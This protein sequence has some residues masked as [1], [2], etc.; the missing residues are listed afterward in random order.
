MPVILFTEDNCA[1]DKLYPFTLTRRIADIRLG[2]LTLRQK[3]ELLLGM[4]SANQWQGDYLDTPASLRLND[5]LPPGLYLLLPANILPNSMIAAQIKKLKS[6]QCLTDETGEVIALLFAAATIKKGKVPVQQTIGITETINR[7]QYGWQLPG[8]NDAALREDFA[9]LTK[10]KRKAVISKTNRCINAGNIFIAPGATVEHC[11]LNAADG[12]VYIDKDATV[13]EGSMLRGPVAIGQG[14]VVKM[15]T[16][17]YGATTIGPHCIAGGEIKNSILFG[18]SNK[19]HDGYLGDS[20]IGEWCN[21]G[22]G[23]SNSNLKNNAGE[24][25]YTTGPT[26]SIK[27][28]LLMGDHS[29]AAINSSFNTAATVGV[30]CNVFGAGLSPKYLLSFSWGFGEKRYQLARAL[31][32]IDGWKKLKGQSITESEKKILKHIFATLKK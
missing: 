32:D 7:L 13:M 4:S 20:V 22:A 21:L 17:I 3:W 5:S 12:P 23:T 10:G 25:V 31:Q 11:I 8:W 18:Y 14:A 30:C 24:V 16:K 2:I 29:K 6:G 27:G 9:L 1:A 19:A 28:G 26:N 15:G